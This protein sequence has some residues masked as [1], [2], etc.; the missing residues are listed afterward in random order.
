MFENNFDLEQPM[1]KFYFAPKCAETIQS[2][3][4]VDYG[5]VSQK[6]RVDDLK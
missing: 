1:R 3:T 6:I 5:L 2:Y 4:K